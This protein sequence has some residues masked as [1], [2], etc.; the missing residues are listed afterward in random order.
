MAVLQETIFDFDRTV[1]TEDRFAIRKFIG[2]FSDT[3]NGGAKADLS[4]FVDERATAQGFSEFPMQ[5]PQIVEMFYKKFFGRKHNYIV[6][7]KLKLTSNNFLFLLTG[8][9]EEY[10]EGILSATGNIDVSLVKE[11]DLYKIVSLK[12]Y[13]RMRVSESYE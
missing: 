13:P 4:L 3:V 1:G 11:D 2:N 9:Y 10:Q 7:P 12:F 5:Q 8:L 6:F